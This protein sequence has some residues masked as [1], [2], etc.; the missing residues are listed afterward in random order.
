M[1]KAVQ[2]AK[3]YLLYSGVMGSEADALSETLV[4]LLTQKK[5]LDARI[6]FIQS[7]L[8]RLTSSNQTNCRSK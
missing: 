5:S 3:Q 1:I 4:L 6:R 8:F 2:T 7:R